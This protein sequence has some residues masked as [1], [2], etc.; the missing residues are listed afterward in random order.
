MFNLKNFQNF[1]ASNSYQFIKKYVNGDRI[2]WDAQHSQLY[3]ET[4]PV[5]D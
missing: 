4:V 1:T 3:E 2:K 5:K